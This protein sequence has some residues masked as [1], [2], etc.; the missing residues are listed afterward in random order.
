MHLHLRHAET[1]S[2]GAGGGVKRGLS[3]GFP[4]QKKAF[5]GPGS[6]L[7]S[8][9]VMQSLQPARMS[10]MDAPVGSGGEKRRKSGDGAMA[11]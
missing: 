2:N 3:D 4:S 5:G 1:A 9:A 10:G 8:S 6:R 7:L 11:G